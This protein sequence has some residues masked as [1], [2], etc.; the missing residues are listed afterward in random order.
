MSE[1]R[2]RFQRCGDLIV[3]G[4]LPAI[5]ERDGMANT[6]IAAQHR[7]N[8]GGHLGR[9]FRKH[10]FR[11]INTALTLDQRN[12]GTGALLAQDKIC[13]PVPLSGARIND[14]RPLLNGYGVRYRTSLLP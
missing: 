6:L 7:D 4:K 3:P 10:L 1:V 9:V 8:G 2:F 12:D 11:Q 13:F 5:I 14:G